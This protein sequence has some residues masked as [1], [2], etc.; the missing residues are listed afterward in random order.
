VARK[1]GLDSGPSS[2]EIQSV[3]ICGST[4]RGQARS[5]TLLTRSVF[6]IAILWSS[7]IYAGPL[8]GTISSELYTYEDAL[9]D[10]VR[11]YLRL[12]AGWTMWQDAQRRSLSFHT[13]T[14]WVTDLSQK[15]T[16]DPET[17]VFDAY[18]KFTGAP[19]GATYYLG[20][21]FVYNGVGSQLLDGARIRLRLSRVWRIDVFGGSSV[22]QE[23]PAT[24]R[25]LSDFG[26]FGA[27]LSVSPGRSLRLGVNWL[28]QESQGFVSFHRAGLD[29][30]WRN[31]LWRIT[32]KASADVEDI[33]LA[34]A[35]ARIEYRPSPWF[36]AAEVF[37]REPSVST[38]TLFSIIDSHGYAQARIEL[39][40]RISGP[41]AGLARVTATG[42][43]G[44]QAWRLQL[45]V[46]SSRYAL[47]WNYQTGAGG[48]NNG[49]SGYVNVPF[50]RWWTAYVRANLNRYRV[51][52]EQ[53]D[54]S[55]AY[56][57]AVGLRWSS[58]GRLSAQGEGQ[59]LRNAVRTDDLRLYLRLVVDI[60]TG[61]QM[62]GMGL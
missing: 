39:Q 29:G 3:D 47:T 55:D 49:F 41:L 7:A 1:I 42:L 12:R 53:E 20:R 23:S 32:G 31:R 36:L 38:A 2:V 13:N 50:E 11:P 61:T 58:G 21:Q 46:T 60:S 54:R 40:R 8:T 10:H 6:L 44:D 37:W 9:G 18:V 24:I 19:A 15:Y 52:P 57:A 17:Y 62:T 33:R 30:E 16:N 5:G 35:L 28:R 27:R 51:Q 59:Y 43:E 14:R 26:S 34:E 4:P 56:T 25:A 45:G 22:A 48:D